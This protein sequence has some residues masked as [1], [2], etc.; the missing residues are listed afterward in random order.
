[1]LKSFFS[2]VNKSAPNGCWE[3]TGYRSPQGYGEYGK[4]LERRTHR[5]SFIFHKGEIGDLF[6]LHKCDNPPCVN[7]DHLFLGTQ[8]ENIKDCSNKK[9]IV[10]SQMKQTHCKYG[11]EFNETNTRISKLGHR[12]CKSCR[13]RIN[14]EKRKNQ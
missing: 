14:A 7:P 4:G 9:R 12:I 2:K 3:W 8:A 13:D 1:M 6:V 5:I 11:H 10:N